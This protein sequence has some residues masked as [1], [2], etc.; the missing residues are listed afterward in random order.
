MNNKNLKF[1]I[2]P[3]LILTTV[4]SI[5]MCYET[6]IQYKEVT[7]TV[8][9]TIASIIGE[10][11]QNN[12]EIELQ[13]IIKILNQDTSSIEYQEGKR[14][15]EKY[16]IDIE[17]INAIKDIENKMSKNLKINIA[18]I[19]VFSIMWILLILI[20]LKRR[21]KKIEE[22]TKYIN[23]IN[24]KNYA[25]KIEENTEDELSHLKNELYKITVMLKEES[26]NSKKDK[27]SLKIAMQDISHQLKTP[28]TS[29]SIIVD[30]LKENPNMN[31]ETKQKFIF[32]LTRQIEWINWL[33]I[34]ILKISRLD[35]NAVD[36]SS[37]RI[38]V[39]AFIKD[40]ISSLE[41]PIEIKNQNI[42]IIGS[43]DVS[44][45]GDIKWQKEAIINIIK[46]CIEH[47]GSGKSIYI[48]YEENYLYTKI[49]IRDEGE[50]IEEK[51]LRHIFERFY[52]GKNSSENSIGI[53]LALSKS[54]IEKNNGII[55]CK[56]KIGEGTEFIIKYMK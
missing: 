56:S 36:F 53:G 42:V 29:I 2:I 35:A 25:L 17:N 33:I 24:N 12:Q 32:E 8:N 20:Y 48:S 54:I 16:G 44:F 27:E 7:D 31:E 1:L 10:I 13:E 37:E 34:S 22:I 45:V 14:E 23:E 19:C 51:D 6:I 46:N 39:S 52:K 38:N 4:T 47:N 40:I 18:T 43:E 26:E 3:I 55:T 11:K 21:D 15:L 30:N 5:I 50:G 28:L 49:S 41:I 9:I